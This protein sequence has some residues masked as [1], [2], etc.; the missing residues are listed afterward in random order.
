MTEQDKATTRHLS[1]TDKSNMPDR[2]FKVMIIKIL[3][4][5][6]KRVEGL[7]ETINTE[8]NNVTDIKGS[9]RKMRTMLYGMNSRLEEAEEQIN[10]LEHRVLESNQ[11]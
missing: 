10:D 11:V 1:K 9:I 5:L 3:A 8:I 7:S 4:Q 6:E 2:E